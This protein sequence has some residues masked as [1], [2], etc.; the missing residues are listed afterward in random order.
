MG[1]QN[2][3][4]FFYEVVLVLN[5]CYKVT[6]S[7]SGFLNTHFVYYHCTSMI[8]QMPTPANQQWRDISLVAMIK[9]IWLTR[10]DIYHILHP[11]ERSSAIIW[12]VGA[13]NCPEFFRFMWLNLPISLYNKAK[14][15]KLQQYWQSIIFYS[16]NLCKWKHMKLDMN[17]I[18][19]IGQLIVQFSDIYL[20]RTITKNHISAVCSKI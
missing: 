9:S 2:D 3:I 8:E 11:I 6:N 17:F 1:S 4:Q 19:N 13:I 16:I 20:T 5:Q 12:V 18:R 10:A 15:W 14:R 7:C